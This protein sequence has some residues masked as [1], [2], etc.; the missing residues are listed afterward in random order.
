M[1]GSSGYPQPP[2]NYGTGGVVIDEATPVIS[3]NV[4]T[5][6]DCNAIQSNNSSPLIENN[7]IDN[8]VD[9]NGFCGFAGGSAIWISGSLSYYNGGSQTN[10]PPAMI[11]G[12]LIQNNTESGRADAGGNGGSGIAVWGGYASIIGNTIRNNLTLGDGG[13]ILAFN[14]DPINILGNLIYNNKALTDGAISLQPPDDS[15]GPFI[16]IVASNTIYGN[17]QTAASGGLFGDSP[18]TQV[19]VDGNL[20]QYLLINNIIVGSG[21]NAVA[22]GCGT[23][24][25]YLS[26]TPLVFDH[27]DL[28]NPT[29]AAYG[30]ACPDQT[31]TYGNISANPKFVNAAVNDYQL[32]SGSPAID[33]ENN[34]APL[35]T[36]TDIAGAPRIQDATNLGYPVVDMG[37]YEMRAGKTPLPPSSHSPHPNTFT[38]R[39]TALPARLPSP[40]P[41]HSLPPLAAPWA[42]SPSTRTP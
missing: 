42:P 26:L 8:T 38:R 34:S 31:G 14:T 17:T 9:P 15:V 3:N 22:V 7:E 6:N 27:N 32:L 23:S 2:S 20:G 1:G 39:I 37:A 11:V 30:G 41:S 36:S 28:Y 24:Y 10:T 25:N 12:N 16:G 18:S 19:Y 5:H 29:G 40:S 13:A 4:L 21:A 35:L 33:T